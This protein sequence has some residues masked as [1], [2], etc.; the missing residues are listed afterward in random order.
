MD[1]VRAGLCSVLVCELPRV[2]TV[3]QRQTLITSL[4]RASAETY[5][6]QRAERPVHRH[7]TSS[8]LLRV[9]HALHAQSVQSVQSA[10]PVSAQR[11]CRMLPTVSTLNEA[12]CVAQSLLT[13]R[14]A[15]VEREASVKC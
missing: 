7:I 5:S 10:L 1:R 4:P 3:R 12:T 14:E 6:E 13:A 8:A 11:V 15:P 2:G 9:S